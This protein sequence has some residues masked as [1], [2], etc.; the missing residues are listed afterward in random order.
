MQ[1]NADSCFLWEKQDT[2]EKVIL[3]ICPPWIQEVKVRELRIRWD[4][5]QGT[6]VGEHICKI[7]LEHDASVWP[8]Q[9]S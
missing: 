4:L 5:G 6:E 1:P 9:Y 3:V 8:N 7:S 2:V